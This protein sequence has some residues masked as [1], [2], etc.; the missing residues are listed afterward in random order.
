MLSDKLYEEDL[1]TIMSNSML[2]LA[3]KTITE[4]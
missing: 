3:K 1:T 2:Y 4:K